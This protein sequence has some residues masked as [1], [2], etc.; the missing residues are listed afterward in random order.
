VDANNAIANQQPTRKKIMTFSNQRKKIVYYCYKNMVSLRSL[1]YFIAIHAISTSYTLLESV[2]LR[3]I[4]A[5]WVLT[6]VLAL[7]RNL[8]L[9]NGIRMLC[10]KKPR[11]APSSKPLETFPYEFVLNVLSTT[12]LDSVVVYGITESLRQRNPSFMDLGVIWSPLFLP[13]FI[14]R[15]F[16][17]EL[18]FDGFHYSMHRLFHVQPFL[19]RHFHKHHH[20]HHHPDLI[21]TFYHH[22][23]DLL[24]TTLVPLCITV[25]LCA[26]ILTNI[27][28]WRLILFY[29]MYIEM[30]GH[31]GR[32]TF[33]TS[34][35][36]QCMWL[37]RLL[38]IQLYS[39]DHE[40]HHSLNHGWQ[41]HPTRR[42]GSCR[43]RGRPWGTSQ[44]EL[45]S[46][47]HPR[48]RRRLRRVLGYR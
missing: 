8:F 31:L 42:S 3:D 32:H 27:V 5:S 16:V 33:P 6:F 28:E 34:G 46:S 37:P 45:C 26:S 19:Y 35:F 47:F 9:M 10:E 43:G 40:A 41:K 2:C 30:C 13:R 21:T 25:R 22:P 7:C 18:V 24:V 29:K 20:R 12:F 36:T 48:H 39:E 4:S 11:I 38:R 44:R 17:F 1:S 15:S 23:I 14:M